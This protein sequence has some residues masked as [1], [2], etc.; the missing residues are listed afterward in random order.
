MIMLVKNLIL[1]FSICKKKKLIKINILKKKKK[2]KKPIVVLKK[3]A[4]QVGVHGIDVID[5]KGIVIASTHIK[6]INRNDSDKT[7]Y[8]SSV[9]GEAAQTISS[10][11][12]ETYIITT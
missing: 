11:K 5:L 7:Y 3:L 8:R 2:K 4:K 12:E 1:I 6:H 9:K 10:M